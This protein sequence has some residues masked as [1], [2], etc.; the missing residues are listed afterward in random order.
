MASTNSFQNK[1]VGNHH[2]RFKIQTTSNDQQHK[3]AGIR[4]IKKD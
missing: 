3:S 4:G 1:G 2:N